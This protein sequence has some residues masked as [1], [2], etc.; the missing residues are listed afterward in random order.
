[1]IANLKPEFERSRA[2]TNQVVVLVLQLFV[3][4]IGLVGSYRDNRQLLL[5]F[6]IILA[7]LLIVTVV[8]N[9]N[10]AFIGNAV[11][12]LIAVI[13]AWVQSHMLQSGIL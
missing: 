4:V 10:V 7:I 9:Q 2:N 12:D 8:Q 3:L 6:A 5:T 1:M 13:L 11:L